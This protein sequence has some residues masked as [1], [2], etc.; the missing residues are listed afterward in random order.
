MRE[1]CIECVV[2]HVGNAEA[3]MTEVIHNYPPHAVRMMGELDQATQE[4]DHKFPGLSE[5]IRQL[6]KL[7]MEHIPAILGVSEVKDR[8]ERMG[9][10]IEAFSDVEHDVFTTWFSAVNSG[11]SVT[12]SER[13]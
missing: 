3:L 8:E 4:C 5:K 6:R 12:P 13:V 9:E 11:E 10:L 7:A 1:T 2:K